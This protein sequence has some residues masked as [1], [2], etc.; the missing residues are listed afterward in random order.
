MRR[1]SSTHPPAYPEFSHTPSELGVSRI[2]LPN[3][4]HVYST[5][6]R[7]IRPSNG[8]GARSR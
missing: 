8:N 6:M 5:R 2:P 3:P 4:S 7:S 1:H